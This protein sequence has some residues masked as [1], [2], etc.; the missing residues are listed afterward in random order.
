MCVERGNL[1]NLGQRQAHLLRQCHEVAGI[2]AAEMVLQQVEMLDQQVAP[3]LALAEQRAHLIERL[4]I[5]L[6]ALRR[7]RRTAPAA[8]PNI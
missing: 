7:T 6:P 1:V 5:D 4:R 3:P 2:E 8:P